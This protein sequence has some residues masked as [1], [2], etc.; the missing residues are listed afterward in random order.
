MGNYM[1]IEFS[2]DG[3]AF[4]GYKLNGSKLPNIKRYLSSVDDLRDG[5]LPLAVNRRREEIIEHQDEGRLFHKDGN[6][7][8]GTPLKWENIFDWW[9]ENYN[10]I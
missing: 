5:N 1:L 8:D 2:K 6:Y 4:Y 7:Q 3:Y 9:L 10:I